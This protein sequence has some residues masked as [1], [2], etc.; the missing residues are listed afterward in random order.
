MLCVQQPHHHVFVGQSQSSA[1]PS[2]A[3]LVAAF[4]EG[5]PQARLE[6]WHAIRGRGLQSAYIYVRSGTT[7]EEGEE[8]RDYLVGDDAFSRWWI[9]HRAVGAFVSSK[10]ILLTVQDSLANLVAALVDSSVST[11]AQPAAEPI[12]PISIASSSSASSPWKMA[13]TQTARRPREPPRQQKV[14]RPPPK[15]RSRPA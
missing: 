9:A 14:R 4:R 6:G 2:L 11:P 5:W 1:E 13:T 8:G 3:G 15:R 10:D 12:T 7:T